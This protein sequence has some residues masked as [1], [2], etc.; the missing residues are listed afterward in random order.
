MVDNIE[1]LKS[2]IYVNFT[3]QNRAR[4]IAYYSE[5]SGVGLEEATKEVDK[6]FTQRQRDGKVLEMPWQWTPQ[7]HQ[8]EMGKRMYH[9]G[10]IGLA[11]M[12]LTF[13]YGF[14]AC[15]LIMYFVGISWKEKMKKYENAMEGEK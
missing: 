12:S 1:E 6:I 14:S 3:P 7:G 5:K 2:Y 15:F 9:I 4:A 11:I 13:V 8:Y 10:F